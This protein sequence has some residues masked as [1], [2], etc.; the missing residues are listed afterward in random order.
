MIAYRALEMHSHTL[1]SDGVFTVEGLCRACKARELDGV[2]L[3][4]HNTTSGW[5]DLNP[6]LE[7]QTLPVV[8]GIEWTTFFGH[9]LVLGPDKYVDWRS[10]APD[11]IDACTSA[12]QQVNG[13]VG[14]AHPFA[15]G[16]PFCTGCHW[17][18]NVRAWQHINYVEVWSEEFPQLNPINDL[19]LQYWTDLL[20]RGHR[21]AAT[22]GRDWHGP[23]NG[24][25]LHMPV[26]YLG[27]EEGVVN[28]RTVR[29]ALHRGRSYVTSGPAIDLTV[30]TRD[31]RACG[32][33]D[34]VRAEEVRV[35]WRVDH[36]ARRAQWEGFDIRPEA[37]AL[38]QNGVP[39]EQ[40]KCREGAGT[41][42]SQTGMTLWPGWLRLELLGS[43]MGRKDQLL[44]FTSPVY[45]Q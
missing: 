9:L 21:L 12:I 13:A 30:V 45:V 4:D 40:I 20:N 39:I 17:E 15:L 32:I 18:F 42:E 44:A 1:H 31:G 23:D 11:T 28:T 34:T 16:S 36:T 10:A 19:A 22:C 14:I 27:V 33:G 3:T 5:Q 6:A 8:R 38:V 29:D 24:K 7:A 26:T 41:D 43:Y 25:R 37:V 35:H 2:A